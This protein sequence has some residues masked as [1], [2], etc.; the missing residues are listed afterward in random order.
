MGTACTQIEHFRSTRPH[1]P[2]RISLIV[3]AVVVA[4]A[5]PLSSGASGQVS[6]YSFL[7]I[8]PSARAAALGG[9]LAAVTRDMNSFLHNPAL[10]GPSE[11]KLISMSYLNHL[12]DIHAGYAAHAR[13]VGRL[14]MA[15]AALR[16]VSWGKIDRADA[17]G[18]TDGSF[19]STDFALTVGA[20]RAIQQSLRYGLNMHY[21][22]TGIDSYRASA[23]L[24][25][26]GVAYH[27]EAQDFTVGAVASHVGIV[28]SSL[29][30]NR[31]RLPLDLKVAVAKRLRHLPLFVHLTAHEVQLLEGLGDV[32]RHLILGGEFQFTRAVFVRFGYNHRRHADL[33]TGGR[34][35]IAGVALGVG[36]QITTFHL[37]YAY[38][39]WSFAGLHQ[40]S[41]QI[42]L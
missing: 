38:S 12:A 13:N 23:L 41:F 28:L 33:G 40:L 6:S 34:L 35:D 18:T 27:N 25:D 31:D 2:I 42:R 17:M 32:P 15:S 16:I 19:T 4:S 20:S 3:L 36:L 22:F 7:Q 1:H 26:A 29:G 30:S 10:I 11:D 14:G 5:S 8:A 37:D 24:I 39:S 21:A 9:S